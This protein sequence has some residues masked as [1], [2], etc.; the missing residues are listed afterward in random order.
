M[1]IARLPPDAINQIAAGEVIER[2]AAAVKELVENALD[3]GATTIRILAEDGG[4][5]RLL[6]EDDG[7]GMAPD[8]LALAIERHATSKL[9]PDSDGHLDLLAISTMGFRGEALPSIGAIAKLSITSRAAGADQAWSLKVEGGVQSDPVPA[10]WPNARSGTRV[11]VRDLFYATPA[12]LNFMKSARAESLAISDMVKR[13]ALARP[14]VAFTLDMDGRTA[15]KVVAEGKDAAAQRAARVAAIL[16][17]DAAADALV[18]EAERG[19][20]RLTGLAGLPTAAR[21]D[22]R[23]QH[24]FVNGRPVKDPLLKGAARAAYQDVLARDRHP[25]LALFLEMDPRLVDV[26]VHPAKT[27]VRFRDPA[28]VRGLVIGA[29]RHALGASGVRSPQALGQATLG[30]LGASTGS[31]LPWRGQS[32][33]SAPMMVRPQMGWIDAQAEATSLLSGLSEPQARTLWP[34]TGVTQPSSDALQPAAQAPEDYPLGA[35]KAQL[36]ATYVIAETAD[37]LVIVDQHAAHERL[38]LERMKAAMAGHGVARQPSLI[39]DIV[40]LDEAD[41]ERLLARSEEFASFGLGIEGFGRGAIAVT[42]TPALLGKVNARKL[43]QDLADDLAAFDEGLSLKERIDEVLAT[44]ACHGSVRAGRHLTGEEMN[45]L[46][47]EM[48][49]T[50]RSGQCNHG[51]PTFV[52]LSL[53]D[54]ERLFGR[55]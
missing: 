53:N 3:A 12:R 15:L 7:C 41:C 26:N 20:I 18:I 33:A 13:L 5:S 49:R 14:D 54:I 40:E 39:P 44:M 1:L 46:L 6:V 50:P 30:A 37:G 35:A 51:R 28:L 36:H 19:E 45:F 29:L 23:H 22:A 52:K 9:A 4:I 16:G 34:E 8:Q 17:K 11:D 38:T 48:E 21:G 32:H 47:R 31:T 42:E 43:L 2:P 55:K 10:P 24:L 27:E 25:V